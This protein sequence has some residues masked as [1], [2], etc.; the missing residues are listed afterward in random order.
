M[1][2]GGRGSCDHSVKLYRDV[3][4]RDAPKAGACFV[5]VSVYEDLSLKVPYTKGDVTVK[6]FTSERSGIAIGF[7]ESSRLPSGHVCLQTFCDKSLY[8]V[9]EK[10]SGEKLYAGNHNLPPIYPVTSKSTNSVKFESRYF[11][12]AF[13]CTG[14]SKSCE[15]PMYPYDVRSHCDNAKHDDDSFQFKFAPITS[16]SRRSFNPN[17]YSKKLSWYPVSPDK[18]TFRSCFMKVAIRVTSLSVFIHFF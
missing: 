8:L 5:S 2:A 6:V 4:I 15:G 11:G 1:N 12:N 17:D 13:D 10:G 16:P 14:I 9:V 18:A 7:T 3:T